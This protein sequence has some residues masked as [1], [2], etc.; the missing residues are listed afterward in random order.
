MNQLS[1]QVQDTIA[2]LRD[3][4]AMCHGMAMTHC[5]E[6]G[7]PHVRPQH[8]RLMLDCAQLCATTAD[9]LERKSQFHTGLCGLCADVNETCAEDCEQLDG[10]D[11]CVTACRAAAQACRVAARLDHAELLRTASRHAP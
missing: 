6:E 9:F 8:F 11:D 3:C 1:A 7:G 10:M 4:H 2:K 5:L